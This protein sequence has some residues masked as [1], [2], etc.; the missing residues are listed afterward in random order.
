[1]AR[2][3]CATWRP[4]SVNMGGTL[5][6]NLG[7]VLHHQAGNGSLYKFFN[8]SSAGVSAHFWV[9]KSGLIEQYVD[10]A[11][12]AWHGRSL[13]SRYVGVE[14]EGCGTAPHAEPMTDAMF[15]ALVRLYAE[16]AKVHGWAN[17]LASKD[18]E[19]GCGFHR[20]AVATGCPCDVRLNRRR[21]ILDRAFGATTT[22]PTQ[23]PV[24]PAPPARP[25]EVSVF[26]R[27]KGT[28]YQLVHGGASSYWRSIPAAAASL[29]PASW[30]LDDP[31][32]VWLG[33]WKVGAAA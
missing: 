22:P 31:N 23:P 28:V 11:R 5:S 27:N 32:G 6:P 19:K 8:S 10:T 24:Q 9:S 26:I 4:I 16:G 17:A 30:V 15:E 25:P 2:F 3:A 13:N 33:L 14:T 7:L 18:G 29:L 21:A 1:M 12:V 20:M